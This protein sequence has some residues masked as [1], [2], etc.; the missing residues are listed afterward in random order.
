MK[1]DHHKAVCVCLFLFVYSQSIHAPLPSGL[2]IWQIIYI[3]DYE[4]YTLPDL[5]MLNLHAETL[6]L[7]QQHIDLTLIIYANTMLQL[8]SDRSVLVK[9]SARFHSFSCSIV[10]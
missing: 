2:I 1:R 6:H 9:P 3:Y 5:V 10:H 4:L 7:T 8:N